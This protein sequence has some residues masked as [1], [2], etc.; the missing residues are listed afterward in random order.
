MNF[1]FFGLTGA[2]LFILRRREARP[3]AVAA[4]AGF[5]AP[6]HPVSTGVFVLACAVV[7]AASFVAYP[8]E[9]LVGY[10]FLV[11]GAPVYLLRRKARRDDP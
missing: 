1:L 2:S 9:S 10:G 4:T 11:L 3:G 7:V 5:R 8:V 6:W